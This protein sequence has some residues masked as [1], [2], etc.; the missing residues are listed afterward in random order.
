YPKRKR[1]YSQFVAANDLVFD[2][3]ANEGNR[4]RAFS[5]LGAR[6]V[7]LEP[8]EVC[9]SLLERRFPR[10]T[11]VR[12]AVGAQPGTAVIRTP[13][14]STIASMSEEFIN[15]TQASG[16]FADY[17]WTGSFEVQVTTLDELIARFGL[18]QF[19]KIDVEGFEPDVV[20]GLSQPV[21]ALSF[22]FAAEL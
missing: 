8:L 16:R 20:S 17:Q 21:K 9:A 10:V 18:P 3:G 11:V 22:E 13:S 15:R 7:A 1:F 2:V 19:V 5:A 14:T 12:E 4:V 6:V